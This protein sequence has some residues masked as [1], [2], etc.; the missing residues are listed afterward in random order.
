VRKQLGVAPSATT[1]AATKAYADTKEPAITAGTSAQYLRGDK[2]MQTLN[3]AAV[4]EAGTVTSAASLTLTNAFSAYIF[5]GSSAATW[6]LPAVSG[7]TGFALILANRGSATVTVQRAGTDNIYGVGGAITSFTL[8]AGSEIQMFNDSVYWVMFTMP[9]TSLNAT[10]TPSSTTYLGGDGSWSTPATGVTGVIPAGVTTTYSAS[11]TWTKPTTSPGTG[12]AY[13]ANDI[14]T[15]FCVGPGRGGGAA[16]ATVI[17]QGGQNGGMIGK[18]FRYSAL[19]ATATMTI[20]AGTT[21][22]A[23]AG[24]AASAPSATTF[25]ALVSSAPAAGYLTLID[26][27]INFVPTPGDGGQ[28]SRNYV[29]STTETPGPGSDGKSSGCAA[30]GPAGMGGTGSAG[31]SAPTGFPGGGGGGG[32][33]SATTGTA[34]TVGGAGGFPGGGGGGGGGSG[35]TTS[36]SNGGNGGNGAIYVIAPY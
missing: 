35:N 31:A 1:D 27:S 36:G 16:S 34:G 30:G 28:G 19:P 20:P 4:P 2:S 9:V 6:T 32:G 21:G 24:A 11:A 22:A 26:G 25:G 33:A 14:F 7:N 5:S 13:Q 15:V 23:T 12:T 29:A 10:G 3:R 18:Q 8:T 17:G